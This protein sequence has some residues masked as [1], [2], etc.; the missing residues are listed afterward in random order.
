MALGVFWL[1]LLHVE[2]FAGTTH[3]WL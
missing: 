3:I 1:C 2:Q